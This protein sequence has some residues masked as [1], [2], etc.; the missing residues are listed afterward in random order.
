M[1]LWLRPIPAPPFGV[2]H[3][4]KISSSRHVHRRAGLVPANKAK[5]SV[6]E[7]ANEEGQPVTLRDPTTDKVLGKV[8][9]KAAKATKRAK[10]AAKAPTPARPA[11]PGLSP[12]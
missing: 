3:S 4:A 5:A 12:P 10:A 1:F 6:Q 9:P 8:K 7:A 11:K 2:N